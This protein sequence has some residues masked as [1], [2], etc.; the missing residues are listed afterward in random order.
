LRNYVHTQPQISPHSPNFCET[1]PISTQSHPKPCSLEA[2]DHW[3]FKDAQPTSTFPSSGLAFLANARIYGRNLAVI[4]ADD[5]VVANVSCEPPT[6]VEKH[7][8]FSRFKLPSIHRLSGTTCFLAC[9]S[10]NGYYHWLFDCIA[11]IDTLQRA[12][13]D[14]KEPDW[15]VFTG[16][17]REFQRDTLAALGIPLHKV[18]ETDQVRH[19]EAQRLLLPTMPAPSGTIPRWAC[20]FLRDQLPPAFGIGELKRYRRL[21]VSREDA[22]Y[23]HVVNEDKLLPIL[24]RYGFEKIIPGRM[25]MREQIATFAQSEAVI[26]PHGAGLSNLVFSQ[27]NTT[28]IEL[29]SPSYVHSCYRQ[30]CSGSGHKYHYLIGE[31]QRPRSGVDPHASRANLTISSELL[32]KLIVSADL[33][34]RAAS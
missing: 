22:A 8:I 28:V 6:T 33:T 34:K 10:G 17:Q 7:F 25:S 24:E 11:R 18:V 9:H 31:G 2:E 14:L 12:G 3:I 30:L 20:D 29:F 26:G 4:N 21:Y 13:I 27:K 15:F 19:I 23:R 32:Q 5:Q 1:H 16:V